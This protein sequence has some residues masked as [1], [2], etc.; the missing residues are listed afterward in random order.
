MVNILDSSG[1]GRAGH[2][3]GHGHGA[4]AEME[5][6]GA[7][8]HGVPDFDEVINID[9]SALQVAAD[10]VGL[11]GLL[12]RLLGSGNGHGLRDGRGQLLL[13][14]LLGARHFCRGGFGGL[15]V[16]AVDLAAGCSGWAAEWWFGGEW[17]ALVLARWSGGPGAGC[18]WCGGGVFGLM[19]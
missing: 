2:G 15:A 6:W 1:G 19:L 18:S 16:W 8:T 17:R 5:G 9:D 3:H 14:D 10:Q 12:L 13:L 11:L 4:A 7:G